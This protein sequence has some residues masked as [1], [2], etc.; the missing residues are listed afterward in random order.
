MW[1]IDYCSKHTNLR[2]YTNAILVAQDKELIY[3]SLYLYEV[4]VIGPHFNEWQNE[5]QIFWNK[6]KQWS[7]QIVFP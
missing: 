6:N 5:V 2:P 7:D 1:Y 4:L 3:V